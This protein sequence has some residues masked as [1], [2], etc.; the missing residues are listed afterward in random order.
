VTANGGI[1]TYTWSLA[2]GSTL[3]NGWNLSFSGLLTDPSTWSGAF[4]STADVAG[5]GT[6]TALIASA[7]L[8]VTVA[9]AASTAHNSYLSGTWVCSINGYFDNDNARWA[10]LTSFQAD[11]NGNITGGVIDENS[12]DSYQQLDSRKNRYSFFYCV[13]GLCRQDPRTSRRS[14]YVREVA[15][16]G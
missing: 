11:G 7:P 9:P 12:R 3:P 13:D 4:D 2:S 10:A 6:A 16:C 15:A 1:P 14:P 8:A 5:S